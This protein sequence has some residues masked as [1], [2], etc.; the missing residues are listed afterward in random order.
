MREDDPVAAAMHRIQD[1]L[2]VTGGPSQWGLDHEPWT[3][4]EPE[5]AELIVGQLADPRDR[6]LGAWA[7]IHADALVTDRCADGPDA[8]AHRRGVV[9]VAP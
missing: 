2:R 3:V 9:E 6:D 8:V 1:R 5:A 4:A 7:D